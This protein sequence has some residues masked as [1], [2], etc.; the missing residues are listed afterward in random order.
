MDADFPPVVVVAFV[1]DDAWQVLKQRLYLECTGWGLI[2]VGTSYKIAARVRSRL[3][4]M[5]WKLSWNVVMPGEFAVV[6]AY[7]TVLRRVRV[8]ITADCCRARCLNTGVGRGYARMPSM[9][10][11]CLFHARVAPSSSPE[12]ASVMHARGWGAAIRAC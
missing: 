1:I 2:A 6:L 3:P 8:V 4:V 7:A 10:T 9:S 11:V 12:M 5:Q